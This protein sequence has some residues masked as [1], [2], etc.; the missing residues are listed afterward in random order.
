MSREMFQATCIILMTYQCQQR[1]DIDGIRQCLAKD[2][3]ILNVRAC[4]PPPCGGGAWDVIWV[5]H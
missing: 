5:P 2:I 1:L 4:V 3:L